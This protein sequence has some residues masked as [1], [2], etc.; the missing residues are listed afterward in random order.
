MVN[1]CIIVPIVPTAD[2]YPMSLGAAARVCGVVIGAM[3]VAQLFS[4]VYFSACCALDRPA[5]LLGSARAVNRRYISDCVPLKIRMQAS[6]GF[7]STS[8]LG[9]AC[10]PA[11]AGLLQTSFEIYKLTFNQDTLPGWVMAISWLICT[12]GPD[13]LLEPDR[14]PVLEARR[15][16]RENVCHQMIPICCDGPDEDIDDQVEYEDES[17]KASKDSR[18]PANLLLNRLR[19]PSLKVQLLIN[20]MLKYAMEILLFESSV[21]TITTLVDQQARLRSSWLVSLS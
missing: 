7:V 9:I 6:A 16:T 21:I 10:G 14:M 15:S 2:D 4:S 17:E 20:I 5:V 8:A 13:A 19:T 12:S 3:A 18:T 11:L 1:T